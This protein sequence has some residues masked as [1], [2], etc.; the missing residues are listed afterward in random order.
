MKKIT[1]EH[2][3]NLF[4]LLIV[5]PMALPMGVF[6]PLAIACILHFLSEENRKRLA[7]DLKKR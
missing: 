5:I 7:L 4:I 2:K 3:I 1:R 6:Y